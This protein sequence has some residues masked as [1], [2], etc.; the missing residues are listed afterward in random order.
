MAYH[1]YECASFA[2]QPQL[3][4]RERVLHRILVWREKGL[5]TEQD[6]RSLTMLLSHPSEDVHNEHRQAEL[7]RLTRDAKAA[8]DSKLPLG[9]I[10]RIYGAVR[11]V[12]PPSPFPLEP[13]RSRVT[14]GGSVPFPPLSR[15]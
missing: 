7:D 9:E 12:P 5:F 1:Q 8:T 14:N 15:F 11:Q 10:K 13:R 2:T 6:W 3:Q 4:I